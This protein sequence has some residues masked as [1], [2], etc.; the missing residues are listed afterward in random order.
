VGSTSLRFAHSPLSCAPF[1]SASPVAIHRLSR[2][3]AEFDRSARPYSTVAR[4]K[5]T[6]SL[7]I[8][9][10]GL[11]STSARSARHATQ[12]AAFAMDVIRKVAQACEAGER[13]RWNKPLAHL[14]PQLKAW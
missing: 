7:Y 3:F 4:L 10:A 6:G 2:L 9:T 5:T 13:E 1:L 11:H 14:P 8:A 12:L